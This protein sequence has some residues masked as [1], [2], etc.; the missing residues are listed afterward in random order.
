M[1]KIFSWLGLHRRGYTFTLSG[2]VKISGIRSW[3]V[4]GG[5]VVA[6]ARGGRV[7]IFSPQPRIEIEGGGVTRIIKAETSVIEGAY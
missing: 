1:E 5:L 7:V 2:A 4:K 6:K 3:R